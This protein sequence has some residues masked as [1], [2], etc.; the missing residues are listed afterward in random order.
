MILIP[1][2]I[3]Y[4]LIVAIRRQC[5]QLN[6]LK[7]RT[8]PVPVIVVGNLSVGGTGKTPLVV[9]LISYLRQLGYTPGVVSRGYGGRYASTG[10]SARVPTQADPAYFG[11]EAVFIASRTQCPVVVGKSRVDAARTLLS[12]S[13]CNII[14]SDDGL[15]HLTLQRDIEILV[16][17]G[18]RLFGNR[19]CLPAG[20]LREPLS[21][22]NSVDCLVCNGNHYPDAFK[23]ELVGN[24]I[25][26]LSDHSQRPLAFLQDTFFHVVTAIGHP[27]R[28]FQTLKQA[29]LSFDTRIYAD[30]H[31]FSGEEI[32]YDDDYP[33]LM[34][35]KDAV[36][37]YHLADHNTWMLPVDARLDAGFC[38]VLKNLLEEK[39]G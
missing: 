37:C 13:A 24:T 20:P 31:Q 18:M 6:L 11:D 5:Y 9:W 17:D 12:S 3:V 29:G 1:L 39:H 25:I 33:V 19:H 22:I 21:R 14:I 30:H 38:R 2:A 4:Q 27:E 23:M 26:N 15:Q 35:E 36:K 34:T 16:I 28:F 32:L 10:K 7:T 8:I